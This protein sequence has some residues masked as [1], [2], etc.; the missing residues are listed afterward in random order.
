MSLYAERVNR[1]LQLF[2]AENCLILLYE[3]LAADPQTW[4]AKLEAFLGVPIDASLANNR[5]R[6]SSDAG[7]VD[8]ASEAV[9]RI[10]EL[11]AADAMALEPIIGPVARD[12]ADG[13]RARTTA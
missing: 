9:D 6:N 10:M 12:W 8:V 1:A 4:T 13:N 11:F 5:F 7:A 3:D 2:G